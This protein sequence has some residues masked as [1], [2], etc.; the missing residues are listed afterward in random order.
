MNERLIACYT[1][2]LLATYAV[3]IFL[4]LPKALSKSCTCEYT[5]DIISQEVDLLLDIRQEVDLMLYIR[6][7]VDLM[8]DIRQEV[9]LTLTSSSILLSNS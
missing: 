3:F 2:Q 4:V 9:D 7:E 8:L 5:L 1:T 6:Q